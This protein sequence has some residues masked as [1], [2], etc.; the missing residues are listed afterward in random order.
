MRYVPLVLA[1]LLLC[2]GCMGP[3][4]AAQYVQQAQRLHDGALASAVTSNPDLRDY[5]QLVGKRIID[6]AR[7]VEPNRTYDPIFPQMKFHLVVSSVPNV[8][9]TGGS[10]IY[11]Y[12]ALFQLCENEDE[13]A[14][15]MA[16]AYAHAIDLDIEHTGMNPDPN[17]PLSLVA[18]Q[19]VIHRFTLPQEQAADRLAF[20]IYSKAGYDP[21]QYP[22][23]FERLAGMFPD[24][25][26]PDR[27]PLP[28]RAQQARDMAAQTAPARRPLPVADP[29]T[30]RSLHGQAATLNLSQAN[31]EATLFLRA[32]P[33]CMLS[34]DTPE[35]QAAQQQLKPIPPPTRLEPS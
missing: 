3:A 30:F 32:F 17:A 28:L 23:L 18:W 26:F 24:N 6:A 5:M 4:P 8:F 25:V 33:N 22:A 20:Q 27:T 21:K 14:A 2:S 11:I 31:P 15:A 1:F 29:Q 35:Q 12:N 34:G 10:H 19:F 13:L 7:A 16:H 9:T